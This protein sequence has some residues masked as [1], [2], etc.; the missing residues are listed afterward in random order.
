MFLFD[1]YI[2]VNPEFTS[3]SEERIWKLIS[4]KLGMRTFDKNRIKGQINTILIHSDSSL[5]IEP[6]NSIHFF[7]QG[8]ALFSNI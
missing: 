4:E 8:I 6:Q 1:G 3:I 2:I 7:Q 5:Q